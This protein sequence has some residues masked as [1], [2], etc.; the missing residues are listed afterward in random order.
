MK[1]EGKSPGWS[2]SP[3]ALPR[4]ARPVPSGAPPQTLVMAPSGQHGCPNTG[5]VTHQARG[6]KMGADPAPRI[7]KD[8][9]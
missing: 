7:G 5:R 4:M 1:W 9:E 3:A 8:E 2:G 6:A